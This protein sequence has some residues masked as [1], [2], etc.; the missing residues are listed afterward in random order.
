LAAAP[1]YYGNLAQGILVVG[2]PRALVPSVSSTPPAGA[3]GVYEVPGASSLMA[4]P[5]LRLDGATFTPVFSDCAV[6]ANDRFGASIRFGYVDAGLNSPVDTGVLA[7]GAPGADQSCFNLSLLAPGQ[8]DVYGVTPI[9][10]RVL[11]GGPV[12]H[13]IYRV[14]NP[15]PSW[16]GT[17]PSTGFAESIEFLRPSSYSFVELPGTPE[18][19]NTTSYYEQGQVS[20]LLGSANAPDS[21]GIGTGVV[22]RPRLHKHSSL[23]VPETPVQQG[24]P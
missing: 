23:Y 19:Y 20:L 24:G 15:D 13:A 21:R 6:A 3:V 9:V 4:G 16:G 8:V 5:G 2:S 18:R 10:D 22:H 17:S 7:I 12:P 14:G 11:L 1:D